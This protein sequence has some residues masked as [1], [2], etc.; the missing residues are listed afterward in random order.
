MTGGSCETTDHTQTHHLGQLGPETLIVIYFQR[1]LWTNGSTCDR[2]K[3]CNK[4]WNNRR[5]NDLSPSTYM[6]SYRVCC[7]VHN[8]SLNRNMQP[9]NALNI[10]ILMF[11]LWYFCNCSM[12]ARL[13]LSVFGCP[14]QCPAVILSICILSNSL[15]SWCASSCIGAFSLIWLHCSL[16]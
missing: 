8:S 2:K 13:M 11:W 16:L 14:C 1:C 7:K 15:V 10:L 6:W 4:W 12:L 9:T 5:H 3:S